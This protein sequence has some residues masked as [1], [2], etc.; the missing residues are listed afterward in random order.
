MDTVEFLREKKL[1]GED[2][3]K[4]KIIHDE[5]GELV[6]NEIMDEYAEIKSK[7]SYMRLYAEFENYKK[8]V[9]KEKDELIINTK[10]KMLNS[11]LDLDSDLH[12]AKKSIGESEGINIILNKVHNF[13]KNQGIEEIQTE[14][15]DSDLHEVVSMLETG[16]EKII[17]VVSKGYSINGKPF[18]YPKIILSK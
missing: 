1:L 13:L 12:I 6:L 2:N 15:Y 4:F 11:I 5:A 14:T 16:E 10:A 7:D 3:K 17:D 9:Q 18:R 8:R